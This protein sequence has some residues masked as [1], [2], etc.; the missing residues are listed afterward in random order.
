MDIV[1]LLRKSFDII[2]HDKY[3]NHN[4]L[5]FNIFIREIFLGGMTPLGGGVHL[6]TRVKK[7]RYFYTFSAL[8][9][10]RKIF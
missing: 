3:Y 9:A 1:L 2:T 8:K 7:L 6:H 5:F 4:F 10:P